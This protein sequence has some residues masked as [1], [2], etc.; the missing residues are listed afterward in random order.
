MG[1]R[2]GTAEGGE[3]KRSPARLCYP[4]AHAP[5]PREGICSVQSPPGSRVLHRQPRPRQ[6]R[7]G[8]FSSAGTCP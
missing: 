1:S 8:S 2:E 3:P 5:Q 6:G 4:P 7:D